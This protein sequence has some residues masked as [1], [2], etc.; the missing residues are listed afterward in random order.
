MGCE[1]WGELHSSPNLRASSLEQGTTDRH[2][3]KQDLR[4]GSRQRG[5][6][7]STCRPGVL[8]AMESAQGAGTCS[9]GSRGPGEE[10]GEG[11]IR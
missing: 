1:V 7:L 6:H 9:E 4:R 2:E 11:S 8:T 3:K 10:S 5:V